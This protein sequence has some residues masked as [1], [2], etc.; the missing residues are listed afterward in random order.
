[1]REEFNTELFA[2]GLKNRQ[3][4]LGAAHVQKSLDAA[5]DFT[6]DMQKLVTEWCWGALWG[7]P[8]LDRRTRSIMNLSMLS[9]LNRPH[10]IRLHVRGALN[11]GVSQDEIKEIFLQVAIYCGVPAALDG[12]KVAAEVLAEEKAKARQSGTQ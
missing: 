9:A 4:V 7:R 8:G 10:E 6:A 12:M 3:E 11:N 1:M 5:D 2:K